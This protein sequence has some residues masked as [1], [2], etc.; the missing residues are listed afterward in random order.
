MSA[1]SNL[2][3]YSAGYRSTGPQ[4]KELVR[5]QRRLRYRRVESHSLSSSVVYLPRVTDSP[6][7]QP[8]MDDG[9]RPFSRGA[10][11]RGLVLSSRSRTLLYEVV[12][13]Y[14]TLYNL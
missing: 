4:S 14:N 2:T 7:C 11:T 12:R 6:G 13:A 3:L 8:C 10:E 9:A 5:D 1:Y